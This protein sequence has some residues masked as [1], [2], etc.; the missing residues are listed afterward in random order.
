[1]DFP[2]GAKSSKIPLNLERNRV[3][4][5]FFKRGLGVKDVATRT[6]IPPS[7]V[8]YYFVKFRRLER[9]GCRFVDDTHGKINDFL[10]Y[11]HIE[12]NLNF[13]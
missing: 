5:S 6:N 11:K 1:M 12:A 10:F 7:S 4:Y 8:S 2:V 3:L 9:K 13:L